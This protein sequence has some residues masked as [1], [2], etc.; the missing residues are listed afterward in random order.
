[1]AVR[2]RSLSYGTLDTTKE[3]FNPNRIKKAVVLR[4][5]RGDGLTI[6][7][8]KTSSDWI[9][10]ETRTRK[11]GKQYSI[12]ITLVKDKL[13][14][15]QFNETIEIRTNYKRQPL[16]VDLKGEVI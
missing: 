11:E 6:K 16:V 10:T 4:D 15:G 9:V 3:N 1:M 7:K 2:P 5:V 14:K 8:I 13:P 12:G